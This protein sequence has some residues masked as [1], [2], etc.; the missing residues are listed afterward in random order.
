MVWK[1]LTEANFNQNK[2]QDRT[3]AL[4][5]SINFLFLVFASGKFDFML[6]YF[7]ISGFT[8]TSGFQI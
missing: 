2:S 1:M 5:F 4:F 8:F 7:M 3:I 6:C